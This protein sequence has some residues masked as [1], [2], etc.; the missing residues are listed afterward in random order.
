LR[1]LSCDV[2]G[3]KPS[4]RLFKNS[5]SYLSMQGLAANQVMHVGSSIQRDVA[6]A[7][8]LGM[9]TALYTGDLESLDA[10]KEQLKDPA[11]RPDT[12]LTEL[13]QLADVVGMG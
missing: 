12:L 9:R 2:G 10:T 6:P 3:R 1:T 4:E 8:K 11:T 13:S 7:K 5:L